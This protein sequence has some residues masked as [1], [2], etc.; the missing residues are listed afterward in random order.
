LSCP[1]STKRHR[2][3]SAD[4][5][6]RQ[7]AELRQRGWLARSPLAYIVLDHD[8]GKFFLRSRA[9]AFPGRQIAEF[10]GVTGGPLAEHIDTNILN[11][12]GERHRRLRALLGPAARTTAW[13]RTWPG[14][15]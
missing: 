4:R 10:F 7:L 12:T 6:H 11:L 1:Y 9:T 2:T 8:S 5:Y 14:P 3:F 13:A 15:N